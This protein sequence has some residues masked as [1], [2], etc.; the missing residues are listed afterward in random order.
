MEPSVVG[1]GE[2][3]ERVQVPGGEERAE[4]AAI[5]SMTTTIVVGGRGGGNI[6]G[7]QWGGSH[8]DIVPFPW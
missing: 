2:G 6:I 3:E 1:E 4:A 8:S 7:R 5:S